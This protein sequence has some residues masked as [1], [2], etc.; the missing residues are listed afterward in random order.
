MFARGW[1]LGQLRRN[2]GDRVHGN[3]VASGLLASWHK[4]FP[5][6]TLG[7]RGETAAAKYLRRRGYVIVARGSRGALGELDLVAVDGRTIV[8]VEVKTRH[9]HDAGHPAEA[10]DDD[11]QR[12]LTR[13]AVAY[14]RR[15][16]LLE[17]AARFD[18]VAV[19]WPAGRGKPTIEHFPRAFTAVGYDGM[20]S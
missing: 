18:V 15:H 19:T 4:L 1:L 11:K 16:G 8:F 5:T 17:Y 9:S 7:Q 10:V 6:R 12:K 13:L 3:A 20:F 14:L 2:S